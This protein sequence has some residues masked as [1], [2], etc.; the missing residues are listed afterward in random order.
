MTLVVSF[1]VS[2][3]KERGELSLMSF[4]TLE[5]KFSMTSETGVGL[6]LLM[7]EREEQDFGKLGLGGGKKSKHRKGKNEVDNRFLQSSLSLSLPLP[8][9]KHWGLPKVVH[10]DSRLPQRL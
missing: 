2:F 10:K 3:K 4:F 5:K 1:L 7:E 6:S 8:P 9:F